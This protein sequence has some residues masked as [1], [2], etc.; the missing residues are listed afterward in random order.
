[1][2]SNAA[3]QL[4]ES[5]SRPSEQKKGGKLQGFL[6]LLGRI[7]RAGIAAAPHIRRATAMASGDPRRIA[8]IMREDEVAKEEERYKE[9]Q[10]LR[11][12]QLQSAREGLERLRKTPLPMT[13]EQQLEHQRKLA[14]IEEEFAAPIPVY[15]PTVDTQVYRPRSE[16]RTGQ[17]TATKQPQLTVPEFPTDV[18]VP[19]SSPAYNPPPSAPPRLVVP[20]QAPP[21]RNTSTDLQ[22]LA[23]LASGGDPRKAMELIQ[24]IRQSGQQPPIVFLNTP[25][26]IVPVLKTGVETGA[27]IPGTEPGGPAPTELKAA[28]EIAGQE[29]SRQSGS[30]AIFW[31]DHTKTPLPR[32]FAI[33]DAR[34]QNPNLTPE[35]AAQLYDQFLSALEQRARDI[36]GQKR[37]SGAGGGGR[38]TPS[39][40]TGP[41]DPL[42]WRK[43]RP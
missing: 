12:I 29:L 2:P 10:A 4:D 16:V 18:P 1:M 19:F 38:G 13:P 32:E 42:G 5:A 25:Q 39:P 30:Y 26:G 17:I 14:G 37:T 3:P 28:R 31:D 15:D 7:G 6:R 22:E 24:R 34:E 41:A 35:A 8:Q 11:D 20:A 23:L 36:V 43:P 40:S 21:P 33:E 27:V 9:G